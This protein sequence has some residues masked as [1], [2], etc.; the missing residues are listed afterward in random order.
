VCS[1]VIRVRR[2]MMTIA[3]IDRAHRRLG[4]EDMTSL[5]D[6]GGGIGAR[7]VDRGPH[8]GDVVS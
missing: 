4:G 8:Q 2:K 6:G 3:M 1:A 7:V 5:R